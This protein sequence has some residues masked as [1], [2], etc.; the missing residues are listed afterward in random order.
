MKTNDLGR[1]SKRNLYGGWSKQAADCFN[2]DCE[3]SLCDIPRKMESQ[4][5][6]MKA[7]VLE[8]FKKYGRPTSEN[9]KGVYTLWM[10]F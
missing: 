6:Q 1:Y 3:C 5:C 2:I 4:K 10:K 9:T 7:T 8:L